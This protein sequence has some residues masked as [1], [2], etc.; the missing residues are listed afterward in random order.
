MRK[1]ILGAIILAFL[2]I[3]QLG[4]GS[5]ALAEIRWE[6]QMISDPNK[7][8]TVSFSQPLHAKSGGSGSIIIQDTKTKEQKKSNITVSK[9]GK[10]ISISPLTP[11]EP[12]REYVL[13]IKKNVRSSKN[14]SLKEQILMPFEL[15]SSSKGN[16][17]SA[18][19]S[20]VSSG[21][22][23][24]AAKD[25]SESSST[26]KITSSSKEYLSIITVKADA[27]IKE[28]K[29]EG[30]KMQYT[31]NN[32]FEAALS[33]VGKGSEVKVTAYD[34]NGKAAINQSYTVK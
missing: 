2:I 34:F 7:S 8:W 24:T 33:G 29:V 19:A 13:I 10:S 30:R 1:K 9:D 22:S 16:A 5:S 6:K 31:G 15:K 23:E 32:T 4:G 3:T 12:G 25:G 21:K 28:I 14:L 11:Y 20:A 26:L 27:S 18:G 17:K